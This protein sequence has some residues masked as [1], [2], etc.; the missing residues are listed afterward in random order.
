MILESIRLGGFLSYK[1]E[2]IITFGKDGIYLVNGCINGDL[3]L[4]NG[5]GKSSLFEAIPVCFWGKVGGRGEKIDEYINDDMDEMMLEICFRIDITRY[6]CT[7]TKNRAS[8]VNA[9]I[10]YDHAGEWKKTDKTI[11]E[12]LGLGSKTFSSTLYLSEREALQFIDGTS[13]ERKEILRELLNIEQYEV[14][15]KVC[16]KR[17]DEIDRKINVNISV[18]SNYQDELKKEDDYKRDLSQNT[19]A[20]KIIKDQAKKLKEKK[21]EIDVK[22]KELELK[23]EAQKGIKE[24]IETEQTVIVEYQK[25]IET[26]QRKIERFTNDEVDQSSKFKKAKDDIEFNEIRKKD[27]T[28]KVD[29]LKTKEKALDKN[30]EKFNEVKAE[31][32]RLRKQWNQDGL[33]CNSKEKESNDLFELIKKVEKFGS[34]CPVTENKCTILSEE[35]KTTFISEKQT[36]NKELIAIIKKAHTDQEK[37]EEK[38]DKLEEEQNTR[39]ESIR[40][41]NQVT[42]EL[43]NFAIELNKIDND[44]KNFDE[45]KRLFEEFLKT[46]KEEISSLK[47]DILKNQTNI[48]TRNEKIKQLREKLNVSFEQDLFS[49]NLTIK[50]LDDAIEGN[51]KRNKENGELIAVLNDKIKNITSVKKQIEA[52]IK[53]NEKLNLKKKTFIRLTQIFGKEGIQKTLMKQSIPFL[54][55]SS[56]DLLKIFNNDSEKIKIKFDL[57]PK[58][59]VGDLKK[60]GGLDILVIEEDREPKDLRMYSGGERVKLIF[61]VILGLGKLLTLRSG[62]KHETLIIDEKIAKLDRRGIEQFVE[63]VNIIAEWY[64]KIFIITHIESLKDMLGENEILINKNEEEGSTVLIR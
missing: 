13:N 46:N 38:I 22:K 59:A 52:I 18:V 3:H 58:T 41:K 4:S 50:G 26:K 24:Q 47:A 10:F 37:L 45:K 28:T 32:E 55:K 23:I 2:Q 7:R 19:D 62:K 11:D 40:L 36:K 16:N 15:A 29:A 9:E 39:L 8:S 61:S 44:A 43:S 35:Y 27:L 54:E 17:I 33:V 12:I 42:I 56:T 6:K 60:T 57:D 63:V 21:N 48:T 51:E 30:A 34:V 25:D 5:A 1:E 49:V 14:A 31:I 20:Q 64:K 53:E